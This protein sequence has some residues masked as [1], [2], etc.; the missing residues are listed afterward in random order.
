[1]PS[2]Y[3]LGSSDNPGNVLMACL[4]NVN[5]Y[6]TW[7]HAMR[8]AL[9]AKNKLGFIDGTIKWPEE[10]EPFVEQWMVCKSHVDHGSSTRWRRIS[11]P[12]WHMLRMPRCFGMIWRS[13]SHKV[14]RLKFIKS[15]LRYIYLSRKSRLIRS[16][17]QSWKHFGMSLGITTWRFQIARAELFT[18]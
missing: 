12:V 15:K 4:L 5:N 3:I 17:T 7:S 14:T 2:T 13:N 8:N 1:M 10:A 16:I 9:L 18:T 6:L 11:K